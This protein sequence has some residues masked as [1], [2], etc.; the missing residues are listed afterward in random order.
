MNE[1]IDDAALRTWQS[2]PSGINTVLPQAAVGRRLHEQRRRTRV[3]LASVAIIVPSWMAAFWFR[4]D[5]RPVA[6]V[7]LMA[8]ASLAWLV[9]RRGMVPSRSQAAALPCA[10]FQMGVLTRERDFHRSMP[11]YLVPV[12]VG[13]AAIVATL[14][15]NPR[16][17]KNAVFAGLLTVFVLTVVAVLRVVFRRSR[18]MLRE[19]ERELSILGKGVET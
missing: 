7:G 4:P 15:C 18:R 16:F 11:T 9:L 14:L 3:F 12:A 19:I 5:L 6:V 10:A 8:A 17:E 2:Q 1:P 13:Q